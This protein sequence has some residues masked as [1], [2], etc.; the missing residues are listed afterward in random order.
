MWG[1]AGRAKWDCGV[2]GDHCCRDTL[3]LVVPFYTLESAMVVTNKA[4]KERFSVFHLYMFAG[5]L[6]T[7]LDPPIVVLSGVFGVSGGW[8]EEVIWAGRAVFAYIFGLRVE[9]VVFSRVR[10]RCWG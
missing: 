9:K 7:L 1:S 4:E 5:R 3:G 8:A 6:L 10:V 2:G